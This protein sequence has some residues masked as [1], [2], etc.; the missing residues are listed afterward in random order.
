ME[1][2]VLVS[3]A[4]PWVMYRVFLAGL[5]Y[6]Y[7]PDMWKIMAM[8]YMASSLSYVSSFG[9]VFMRGSMVHHMFTY[10]VAV[11]VGVFVSHAVG[12]SPG[13]FPTLHVMS[14][15]PWV[16][17]GFYGALGYP[18]FIFPYVVTLIVARMYKWAAVAG[19]S[20]VLTGALLP[21]H[22]PLISLSLPIV[23]LF[24][25]S[26]FADIYHPTPFDPEV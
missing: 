9:L 21:L 25:Y 17:G 11:M 7:I 26:W 4:D 23:V 14:V 10:P 8:S 22:S 19:L 5:L 3:D 15:L 20:M 12:E 16:V 1:W 24:A 2:N 13:K 6:I 18:A